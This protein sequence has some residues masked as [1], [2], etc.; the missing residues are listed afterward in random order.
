M[1]LFV[2]L[3]KGFKFQPA[4]CS[5]CHGVVMISM[6]LNNIAILNIHGFDYHCI[7]NGISKKGVKNILQKADLSKKLD[8]HKI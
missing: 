1:S 2:F 3:D 8:Y 4:L 6:N 5:S 7:V